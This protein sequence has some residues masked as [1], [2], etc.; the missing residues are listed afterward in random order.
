MSVYDSATNAVVYTRSSWDGGAYTNSFSTV[1]F[2]PVVGHTYYVTLNYPSGA[3]YR[4]KNSVTFNGTSTKSTE[5]DILTSPLVLDLNGDGV[6]TMDLSHAVA[7]DLTNSGDK[8]RVSWIDKHDGL[9]AVDLNG[10]GQIN[11]GAELLGSSTKLADGSVAKDG[12]A[13]L[14]AMDTNSD[15]KVDAQDANFDKLRVWV[16][17]DTDG[18]TDAGELKSLADAGIVSFDLNQD[19]SVTQ[20]NG[21]VLL[22]AG[23]YT[24]TDGQT[25]AMTDAWLQMTPFSVKTLI[26]GESLDL[27]NLNSALIKS[28][29]M[30]TDT[31]ANTLKLNLS[32]VLSL[33]TTNGVH[34]L[35]LTGDA[36]DTVD[37]D[38]AH[39]TNTGTTVTENGHSYAVYST[40]TDS[41]AQL[42]ID[43]HMLM[44]QHS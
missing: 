13:A 16:D 34:K 31:A 5:V 36:N 29:D 4:L 18:L 6:Q 26:N 27:S 9:L 19:N 12:W 23:K 44:T 28:I 40:A 2:T 32:D 39:W 38:I 22:G 25:H 10:D 42:L 37:L 15:G 24:T 35:T 7:F 1:N 33:P 3:S 8:Q 14:A 43:Q 30:S 11:G 21:N 20:Q 41:S 17:A